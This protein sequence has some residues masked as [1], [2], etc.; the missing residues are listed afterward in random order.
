STG[1]PICDVYGAAVS[2]LAG[3]RT[4]LNFLQRLS[5]IA[6]QTAAFVEAVAGTG[7]SILDTRKTSPG[8]RLLE[9]YAVR[10]GGGTNH[11]VGLYDM[12]LIKDNHI[13]AAGGIRAAIEAAQVHPLSAEL[14]MVV[15]VKDLDELQTALDFP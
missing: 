2:V 10:I 7:A 11:R 4:A 6:T 1:T 8:W 9:K 14:P 5:G 15:E 12:L 13:D 3:E